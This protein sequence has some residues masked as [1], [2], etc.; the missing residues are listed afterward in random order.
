VV[1]VVRRP[2]KGGFRQVSRADDDSVG[3]ICDVHQNLRA[4]P[5]L[6]VF[7][8]NVVYVR[9]VADVFEML[10]D[11]FCDVDAAERDAEPFG[12]KPGIVFGA[13]GGSETR[14]AA[15]HNILTIFL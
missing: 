14:H 2:A 6:R 8:H 3:L 9:I 5:R 12:K 4:L 10:Q 7:V 13:F 15:R 11:R 1:A